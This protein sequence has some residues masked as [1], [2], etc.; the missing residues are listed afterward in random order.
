MKKSLVILAAM[1]L[2]VSACGNKKVVEVPV[3]EPAVVE[4][5][6]E[7]PVDSA[8]VDTVVVAE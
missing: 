6:V 8:A 4:E 2:I 7:A 5:V 3:E 1:A